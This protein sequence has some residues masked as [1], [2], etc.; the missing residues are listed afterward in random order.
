[1]F[2]RTI[3]EYFHSTGLL[4]GSCIL[5][6]WDTPVHRAWWPQLSDWSLWRAHAPD[7]VN[8]MK[9][10][11]DNIHRNLKIKYIDSFGMFSFFLIYVISNFKLFLLKL[12]CKNALKIYCSVFH[13]LSLQFH[14]W[15]Y[16]GIWLL[17]PTICFT[18]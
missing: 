9:K 16:L 17:Y 12:C 11:F 15:K 3:L 6:V 4:N 1:M 8:R 7:N 10:T 2:L 13:F 14:K 18:K 5:I